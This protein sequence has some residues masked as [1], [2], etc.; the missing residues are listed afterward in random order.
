MRRTTRRNLHAVSQAVADLKAARKAANLTQ[1]EVAARMGIHQS[2]V[3]EV[4]SG[5]RDPRLTWLY[6]YAQAVGVPLTVTVG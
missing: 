2:M 1:V 6:L 5:V 3:S 4:E